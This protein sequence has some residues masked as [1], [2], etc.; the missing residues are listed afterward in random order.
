MRPMSTTPPTDETVASISGVCAVTM[1][2]SAT[3]ASRSEKSRVIVWPTLTTT[4]LR[5][6][7]VKPDELHGHVEA[8][9]RQRAQAIDAFGVARSLRA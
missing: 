6:I 1:T 5:S 9:D 4:S 8:A 2:V 3:L 7:L